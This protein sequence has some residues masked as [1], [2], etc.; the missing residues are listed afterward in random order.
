M[1]KKG[2]AT[3][4]QVWVVV[5]NGDGFVGYAKGKAPG[6]KDA[7]IRA[8][9]AAKK[10]LFY[11]PRSVDNS[12]KGPCSARIGATT[13][14][15][16]PRKIK[17]GLRASK[18]VMAV[19]QRAGVDKTVVKTHGSRRKHQVLNVLFK[20]L[21]KAEDIE[22]VARKRGLR[23]EDVRRR[24]SL[25][26]ASAVMKIVDPKLSTKNRLLSAKMKQIFG[27]N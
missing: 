27:Y 13:V 22:D 21:A 6:A 9:N 20:A 11:I 26:P 19:L 12:V 16:F 14:N 23:V 7:A 15:V 10:S 25:L 17:P 24:E 3:Q 4:Q 8:V 5:G 1:T 18:P 2:R